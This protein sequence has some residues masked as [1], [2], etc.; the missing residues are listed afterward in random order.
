M[1]NAHAAADGLDTAHSTDT[2]DVWDTAAIRRGHLRI[3]TL[4]NVRWMVIVG[5]VL[6]LAAMRLGLGYQRSEERR[7]GKECRSRWS[8]YH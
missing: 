5:E 4:V 6:L 8:P 3:R 7:V 2:Q 1:T